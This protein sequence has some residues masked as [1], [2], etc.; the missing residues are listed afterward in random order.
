LEQFEIDSMTTNTTAAK[1]MLMSK[2]V[3]PPAA[4]MID[5]DSD[6]DE[7]DPSFDGVFEDFVWQDKQWNAKVRSE[8]GSVE[9]YRGHD[10]PRYVEN[11]RWVTFS[12]TLLI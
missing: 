11:A 3:G 7:D 6:R 1:Q 2:Y 4:S 9:L 5:D 12:K 8:D 10:L